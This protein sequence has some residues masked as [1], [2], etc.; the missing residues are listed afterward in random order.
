[1]DMGG[2]LSPPPIFLTAHP[3]SSLKTLLSEWFKTRDSKVSLAFFADLSE[4]SERAREKDF[5]PDLQ[6][7][8]DFL[9]DQESEVH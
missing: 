8:Q 6:D 7:R 5:R 4:R 3:L 1:M 2:G 9:R